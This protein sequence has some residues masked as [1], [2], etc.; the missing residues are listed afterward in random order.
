MTYEYFCLCNFFQSKTILP[1]FSYLIFFYFYTKC[2]FFK[3]SARFASVKRALV[4]FFCFSLPETLV[5]GEM[6]GPSGVEGKEW[7]V[8]QR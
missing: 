6:G 3:K 7:N 5:L 4:A 1:L 8:F 2:R